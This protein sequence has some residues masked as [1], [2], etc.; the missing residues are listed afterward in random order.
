M[1]KIPEWNVRAHDQPGEACPEGQANDGRAE[2]SDQRVEERFVEDR[3]GEASG[4]NALVMEERE[5]ARLSL[6]QIRAVVGLN[7]YCFTDELE[8]RHKNQRAKHQGEQNAKNALRLR[9]EMP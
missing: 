7:G 5:F 6:R 2:G 9:K 3:P 1:Q 8:Q 4:E